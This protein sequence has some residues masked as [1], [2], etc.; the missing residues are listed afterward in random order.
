MT[1][2]DFNYNAANV[3][4]T[5]V[6]YSFNG[7]NCWSEYCRS[8]TS[9]TYSPSSINGNGVITI[10]APSG[11]WTRGYYSI[12]ATFSGTNG[13]ATITGGTVRIKDMTAPNI[14]ISLPINNAT[15]NRTSNATLAFRATTTENSQC[16]LN[17]VSYG[18]F[19]NWYCYNWNSTNS[20]TNST[21]LEGACNSTRYNYTGSTNY[22]DYVSSNYHSLDLASNGNYSYCY[23]QGGG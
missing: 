10:T 16:Y 2:R 12:K 9:A 22:A 19:N 11:G 7:N 17:L 23:V 18:N 21:Q 8:Y 15:Y 14:T 3:N 5:S 13:T 6:S 1:I 4:V 20:T